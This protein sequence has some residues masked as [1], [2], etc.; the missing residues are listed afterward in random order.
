MLYL[1]KQ[2]LREKYESVMPGYHLNKKHWNTVELE[3]G[4]PAAELRKMIDHSYQLVVA[5]LPRKTRTSLRLDSP[6]KR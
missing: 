5:S 6:G 1:T 2:T 4:I 3:G